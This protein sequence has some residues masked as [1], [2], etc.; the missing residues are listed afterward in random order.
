MATRFQVLE[1]GKPCS[2]HRYPEGSEGR[3]LFQENGWEE[4]QFDT[5][6]EAVNHLNIWLGWMG[7]LADEYL[8]DTDYI[9]YDTRFRIETI[10]N[11]NNCSPC[12]I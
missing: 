11:G 1:D 9:A 7:P 2:Y 5:F 12:I 4:Y 3:K 8:P 10:E 6:Q